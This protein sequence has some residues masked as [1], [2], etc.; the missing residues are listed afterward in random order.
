MG[1]GSTPPPIPASVIEATRERYVQAYERSPV[2]RSR[3]G[4][5]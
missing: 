3:R 1:Q 2:V 4:G 5:A